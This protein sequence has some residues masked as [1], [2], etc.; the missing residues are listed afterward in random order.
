MVDAPTQWQPFQ[1]ALGTCPCE[2]IG[3]WS[4]TRAQWLPWCSE[5]H[6]LPMVGTTCQGICPSGRVNNW[7]TCAAICLFVPTS[8][9]CP[10]DFSWW[11]F[12]GSLISKHWV[13]HSLG[14]Q[15]PWLS[16]GKFLSRKGRAETGA[17]STHFLPSTRGENASQTL[18][19]S[20]AF[21]L[22]VRAGSFG[23]VNF[24]ENW[25]KRCA[26]LG[27]NI[28]VVRWNH[29]VGTALVQTPAKSASTPVCYED[30]MNSW[31][32][33]WSTLLT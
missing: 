22:G 14:E 12:L 23:N 27:Y 31:L 15:L 7:V 16:S 19:E 24:K 17:F 28:T 18:P 30:K 25:G 13:N 5:V 33:K 4:R 3:L 10:P 1:S 6:L 20:H 9:L 21:Q 8:L 29:L 26:F 11:L 2:L 32:Y